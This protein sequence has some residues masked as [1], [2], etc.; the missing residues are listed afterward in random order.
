MTTTHAR[1]AR[2][3]RT[4]SRERKTNTSKKKLETQK[5]DHDKCTACDTSSSLCWLILVYYYVWVPYCY[6][7]VACF[8]NSV[9]MDSRDGAKCDGK[10][11]N[12]LNSLPLHL[13][14]GYLLRCTDIPPPIYGDTPFD[15]RGYI[16]CSTGTSYWRTNDNHQRKSDIQPSSGVSIRATHDKKSN[17]T[18]CT[19]NA[20]ILR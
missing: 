16:H 19:C 15:L 20:L 12:K 14:R 13:L 18:T 8:L 3:A 11:S 9:T 4:H 7:W 2:H 6:I 5:I 17:R 1:H 10:T